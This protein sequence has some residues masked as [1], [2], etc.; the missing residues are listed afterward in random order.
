MRVGGGDHGPAQHLLAGLVVHEALERGEALGRRVLGVGVIDVEA[1]AV[2]E[3]GVGQ[4]GLDHRG[5]RALT[6]EAAGV[7]AGGLVLEVPADLLLDVRGVGV[8]QH[9]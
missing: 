1:G 2:G 4:V 7:V 8:H 5:Q 3:D 6:G 9:R